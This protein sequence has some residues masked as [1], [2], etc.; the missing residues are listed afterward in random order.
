[1]SAITTD[2]APHAHAEPDPNESY[3]KASHGIMSW[4]G[5]LDHKRIGVMY[6]ASVTLAFLLGGIF[7]L[8]VRGVQSSTG[9]GASTAISTVPGRIAPPLRA[10]TSRAL[11]ITIGTIGTPAAIAMWNAPFLNGPTV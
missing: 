11:R 1:M 9:I 3:L 7:A 8:I 10:A 5:T 4:L 6:L 2:A